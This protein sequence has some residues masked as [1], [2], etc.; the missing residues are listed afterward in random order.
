MI[1][2]EEKLRLDQGPIA[3][4]PAT[5]TLAINSQKCCQGWHPAL[6]PWRLHIKLIAA[7]W[8]TYVSIVCLHMSTRSRNVF[9][10]PLQED[11]PRTLWGPREK[12]GEREGGGG[13]RGRQGTWTLAEPWSHRPPLLLRNTSITPH[14][15][16][17]GT[18]AT[19]AAQCLPQCGG[20]LRLPASQTTA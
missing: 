18:A 15:A 7:V 2:E 4:L 20:S 3:D 10:T 16:Q 14:T 17:Y 19:T 8:L 5:V 1:V 9:L 11:V 6:K 12:E 13:G